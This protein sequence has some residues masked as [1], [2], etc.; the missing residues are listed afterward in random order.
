MLQK[1]P[2]ETINLTE[3]SADS[4]GSLQWI[5]QEIQ[6]AVICVKRKQIVSCP[7]RGIRMVDSPRFMF[8]TFS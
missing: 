2:K 4:S 3:M 8:N 7:R 5:L 6:L 1:V